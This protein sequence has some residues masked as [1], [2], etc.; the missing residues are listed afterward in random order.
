MSRIIKYRWWL[1]FATLVVFVVVSVG[2]SLKQ[3]TQ[4][5]GEVSFRIGRVPNVEA[6]TKVAA[7]TNVGKGVWRLFEK[8][9]TMLLQSRKSVEQHLIASFPN[10][11]NAG[12]VAF[13]ARIQ[14]HA[15]DVIKIFLRANSP[16]EI[17]KLAERIRMVLEKEHN[18]IVANYREIIRKN[19]EAVELLMAEIEREL[20]RA[21]IQNAQKNTVGSTELSLGN[22][23]VWQ[24]YRDLIEERERYNLLASAPN[25]YPTSQLGNVVVNPKPV[26]PD[27]FKHLLAF[28]FIGLAC[29]LALPIAL[30]FFVSKV[31]YPDD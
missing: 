26:E 24:T 22:A 19:R 28:L 31:S 29:G 2:Y 14:T 25:L 17:R 10:E 27:L 12:A 3:P 9:D 13:I 21:S 15:P 23:L 8:R 1:G 6:I 5:A 16:Q 18:E 20:D 11:D 4:Y 7:L 30:G